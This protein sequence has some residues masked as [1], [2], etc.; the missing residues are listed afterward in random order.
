[1]GGNLFKPAEDSEHG[2]CHFLFASTSVS[3][4]PGG[5]AGCCVP[6]GQLRRRAGRPPT[7]AGLARAKAAG[8]RLG[9]PRLPQAKGRHPCRAES[10]RAARGA[11]IAAQFGV[12]PSTV[13]RISLSVPRLDLAGQDGFQS[14]TGEGLSLCKG[15]VSLDQNINKPLHVSN[16]VG[17]SIS[18]W[19]F[20]KCFI[21]KVRASR[22]I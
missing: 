11:K 1:M 10:A 18:K 5:L 12:D 17:G 13:Q 16:I 2:R 15:H 19:Q 21:V 8:K 4:G 22:M 7:R 20:F 6:I 14:A 9:R 3:P